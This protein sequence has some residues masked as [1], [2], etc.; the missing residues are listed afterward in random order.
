MDGLKTE[1]KGKGRTEGNSQVSGLSRLEEQRRYLCR[2]D[3]DH[4][5]NGQA[6][7]RGRNQAFSVGHIRFTFLRDNKVKMPVGL[8]QRRDL[9]FRLKRGHLQHGDQWFLTLAI[10]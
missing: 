7:E 3:E 1:N 6:E 5:E 8:P 10:Q 4:G 9:G 2:D